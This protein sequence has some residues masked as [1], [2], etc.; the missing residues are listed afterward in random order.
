MQ[1][2]ALYGY[3]M[4]ELQIQHASHLS[5][6]TTRHT[7]SCV[8]FFLQLICNI[9]TSE[10]NIVFSPYRT[11]WINVL[12]QQHHNSFRYFRHTFTKLYSIMCERHWL[13]IRGSHIATDPLKS[14]LPSENR[15]YLNNKMLSLDS[16]E[17]SL[18]CWHPYG[19][20]HMKTR[21]TCLSFVTGYLART[22]VK[23]YPLI[24]ITS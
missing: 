18:T 15:T 24:V 16:W 10:I 13:I 8:C 14:L 23:R 6:L 11:S 4:F 12:N 9:L 5:I 20:C 21:S 3:L 7:T 19:H 2:V 17:T 22:P 1:C